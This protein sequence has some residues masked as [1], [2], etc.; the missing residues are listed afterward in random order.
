MAVAT[1]TATTSAP[2]RRDT[3]SPSAEATAARTASG[4]CTSQPGRGVC[5]A[6]LG[7]GGELPLVADAERHG[8][9]AGGAHVEPDDDLARWAGR[10]GHGAPVR[11]IASTNEATVAT[12]SSSSASGGSSAASTRAAAPTVGPAASVTS[13]AARTSVTGAPSPRR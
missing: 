4:S 5:M 6:L 12:S 8:L 7:H 1:D 3:H 11:S 10:R 2:S 9:D 13:S